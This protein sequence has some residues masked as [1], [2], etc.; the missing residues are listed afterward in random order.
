MVLTE[1][2]AA[3][4]VSK[5]IPS[6]SG[7][8]TANAIRV[9]TPNVS[10]AILQL[11]LDREITKEELNAFFINQSDGGRLQNQIGVVESREVVSSDMVGHKHASIVDLKATIVKGRG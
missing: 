7:K 2:G 3:Q 11:K 8:L 5:C 10:L 4:A 9:P 1:T 6:L